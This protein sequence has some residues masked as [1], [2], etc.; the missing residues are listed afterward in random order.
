[1]V[2]R[3]VGDIIGRAPCRSRAK[4]VSE[5]TREQGAVSNSGVA[6]QVKG[7][8]MTKGHA[9]VDLGPIKDV[10]LLEQG[11]QLRMIHLIC[12]IHMHR[13]V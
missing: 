3:A 11:K 10:D 4:R 6:Q 2:T 1:M 13:Y 8:E 12:G 9:L 5:T 7:S